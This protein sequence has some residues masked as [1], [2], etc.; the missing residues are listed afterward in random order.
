LDPEFIEG[1]KDLKRY[2]IN[3]SETS[4]AFLKSI[5]P[6]S[7]MIR[8]EAI[9]GAVFLENRSLICW[10]GTSLDIRR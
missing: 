6:E 4:R 3:L 2:F 5:P 10:P 8:M 7:K 9:T 1:S